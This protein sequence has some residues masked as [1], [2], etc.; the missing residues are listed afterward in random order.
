MF[1]AAVG[2]D[3][4]TQ[5]YSQNKWFEANLPTFPAI[6]EQTKNEVKEELK[7]VSGAIK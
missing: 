2:A 1:A 7:T 4:A 5:L 3:H 6:V